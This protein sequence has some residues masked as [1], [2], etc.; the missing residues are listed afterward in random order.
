M[1]ADEITQNKTGQKE[2]WYILDGLEEGNT[3]ETRVSYAATV[4]RFVFMLSMPNE[5]L[6][7]KY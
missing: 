3:Y 6:L 1:N 7:I 4:S 5:S 2:K